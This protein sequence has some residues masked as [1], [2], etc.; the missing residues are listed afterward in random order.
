MGLKITELEVIGPELNTKQFT[1][2]MKL[3][4]V[5]IVVILKQ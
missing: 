1:R 5:W 2:E 4:L 3:V